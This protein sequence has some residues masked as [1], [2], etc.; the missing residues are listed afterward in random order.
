MK[1]NGDF[2][3]TPAPS[4]LPKVSKVLPSSLTVSIEELTPP[5]SSSKGQDKGKFAT[6]FWD[7]LAL[8]V[9]KAHD[10]ISTDEL[11]HPSSAI[12]LANA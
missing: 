2:E 1:K 3:N 5:P 7:D 6:N 4:A 12:K 10:V 9:A 8:A 11:K